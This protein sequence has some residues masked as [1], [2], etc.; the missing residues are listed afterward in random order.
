MSPNAVG[1]ASLRLSAAVYGLA[2]LAP[3]E[4]D[5][6]FGGASIF[7]FGALFCCM[8]PYSLPWWANALYWVALRN[9]ARRRW[10]RSAAWG[11]AATALASG[12]LVRVRTPPGD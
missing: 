4:R 5:E 6:W 12:F 8:V 2:F 3:L 7:L 10:G 1:R 11:V 9:A